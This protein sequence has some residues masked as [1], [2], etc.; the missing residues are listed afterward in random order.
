MRYDM[1]S[2]IA[3]LAAISV[4]LSAPKPRHHHHARRPIHATLPR[5]TS[6][7]AL[8]R[9]VS[10]MERLA[11]MERRQ[12]LL[13]DFLIRANT[14]TPLLQDTAVHQPLPGLVVSAA[15]VSRD[16]VGSPIVRVRVTN[17]RLTLV[18]AVL[19]A[20]LADAQGRTDRASSAL[21]LQPAETRTI[22]LLCPSTFSPVSLHWSAVAL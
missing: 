12:A 8:R 18:S 16:L 21:V 22:E 11:L 7:A 14:E 13:H 15:F 9:S 5:A 3:P 17:T 4:A 20:E 10:R 1:L 2:F 19:V 6:E